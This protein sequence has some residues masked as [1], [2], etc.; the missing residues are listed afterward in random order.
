M[1]IKLFTKILE[2]TS[3]SNQSLSPGIGGHTFLGRTEIGRDAYKKTKL[4][5]HEMFHNTNMGE[6][7]I[8]VSFWFK[9]KQSNYFAK[10]GRCNNEVTSTIIFKNH[11]MPSRFHGCLSG[12]AHGQRQETSWRM[13]SKRWPRKM[14]HC[15]SLFSRLL[16]ILS[17]DSWEKPQKSESPAQG[18]RSQKSEHMS[19]LDPDMLLYSPVTFTQLVSGSLLF[20]ARQLQLQGK[21]YP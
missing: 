18:Q 14:P 16:F 20:T 8:S 6:H 10:H 17:G 9:K 3:N 11:F 15:H 5:H 1:V 12:L 21:E 2:N 4:T 7:S 19:D 13:L